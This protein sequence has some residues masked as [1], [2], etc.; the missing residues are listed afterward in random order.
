MRYEAGQDKRGCQRRPTATNEG[1]S[2]KKAVFC[3]KKEQKWG[4]GIFGFYRIFLYL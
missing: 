3:V 4:V 2:A 1:R